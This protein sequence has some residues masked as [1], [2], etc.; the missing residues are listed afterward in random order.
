[1]EN[2]LLDNILSN[3]CHRNKFNYNIPGDI[4]TE[5]S[6]TKNPA[7]INCREL[8]RRAGLTNSIT[9]STQYNNVV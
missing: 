9:K 3:L 8:L 2:T 6:K 1:M 7:L 4:N 5:P